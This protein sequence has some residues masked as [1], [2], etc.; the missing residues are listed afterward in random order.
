MVVIQGLLVLY[1]M[2]DGVMDKHR[3]PQLKACYPW[4][5]I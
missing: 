4:L 2:N 5:D 3:E 1:P